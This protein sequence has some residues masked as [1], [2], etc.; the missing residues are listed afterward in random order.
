MRNYIQAMPKGGKM[1]VSF[2]RNNGLAVVTIK[3][4]GNRYQKKRHGISL[5]AVL[6]NEIE[7]TGLWVAADQPA[8]YESPRWI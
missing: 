3:D 1:S 5:S 7:W 8:D 6:H 2:S 4:T